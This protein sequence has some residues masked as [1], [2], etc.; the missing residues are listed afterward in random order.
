MNVD[1]FPDTAYYMFMKKRMVLINFISFI[2]YVY[3]RYRDVIIKCF[4]IGLLKNFI[5]LIFISVK[6]HFFGSSTLFIVF[7]ESLYLALKLNVNLPTV[8]MYHRF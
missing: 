6:N 1:S 5:F 8:T 2:Y 4:V 3:K 7:S